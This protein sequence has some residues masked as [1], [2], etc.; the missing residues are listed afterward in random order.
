MVLSFAAT[1]DKY[2]PGR[3]SFHPNTYRNRVCWDSNLVGVDIG[4]KI[5][6]PPEKC[7][8]WFDFFF[9]SKQSS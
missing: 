7:S 1:N 4:A 5:F 2:L 6:L 9:C 3:L 8:K